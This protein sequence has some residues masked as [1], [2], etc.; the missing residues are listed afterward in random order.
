MTRRMGT[1]KRDRQRAN[2]QSKLVAAQEAHRKAKGRRRVF[3]G[4]LVVGGLLLAALVYSLVAGGSDDQESAASTTVDPTATTAAD[5]TA[6]TE[7]TAPTVPVTAPAAGAT[8]TGPTTCPPSDGSAE[9][10]TTFSS[11]P[12]TCIDTAKTYRAKVTTSEGELTID[13]NNDKAPL[14]V[15]NF[16][17]LSRFN[18]YDGLPFHRIVTGFVAQ[19]GDA[20]P[21]EGQMGTGG[22]GYT[23]ADE[24]YAAGADYV[25]GV[26][27]MANSGPNT[28]GSQFFIN[29]MPATAASPF[30]NNAVYTIFGTVT[31]GMDTT[32]AAIMAA[33][34][35]GSEGAVTKV[36][37]IEDIEII[38]S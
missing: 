22:P 24:L 19:V 3:Q 1:A 14:A 12:P 36:V 29:V 32:V 34:T 25:P 16:V 20:N 10:T 37:T 38:E 6:S 26:V 7:A 9:R 30:A 35:A 2:R 13:L 23:F 27:A 8:L 17:V 21:R 5:P 11:A 28:N 4:V 18:Y 15:N 31:E 33:G